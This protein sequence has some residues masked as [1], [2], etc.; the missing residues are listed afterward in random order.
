M[1]TPQ[2]A[3]ASER[4]ATTRLAA[5]VRTGWRAAL[6]PQRFYQR[7]VVGLCPGQVLDL[8]CGV[9][10]HLA[11]LGPTSVG[12]DT[13][14]ASVAFARERGL[15]AFTPDEFA[16]SGHAETATFDVL[17]CSHVLEHLTVDGAVEL[18]TRYL[19]Y[20]RR[21][22]RVVAI[23]PQQRGQR[24]DPTHVTSMP[25]ERLAEVLGRAGAVV[26]QVR[27]FPLPALAGRW[28]TH[29]ETIVVAHAPGRP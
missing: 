27:S 17:L 9:G 19:P 7:N 12:I 4:A 20:V 28:F 21:G 10:R 14:A 1:T 8:G 15:R 2:P 3:T 16:A 11:N 18:V 26:D 29:N 22:G 23:C 5:V 25:A 13:N 6:H 24:A